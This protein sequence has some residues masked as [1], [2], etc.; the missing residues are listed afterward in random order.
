MFNKIIGKANLAYQN[1]E[2]NQSECVKVTSLPAIKLSH[3]KAPLGF[4][5]NSVK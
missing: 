3:I 1:S 4:Y 2:E 5:M